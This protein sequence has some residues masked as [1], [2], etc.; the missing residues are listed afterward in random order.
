LGKT[1]VLVVANQTADSDELI[2]VLRTRARQGAARFTLLVPASPP[3]VT[4]D[5]D[6][7]SRSEE[8]GGQMQRALERMR[9]AGLDV[10]GRLGAPDPVAAVEGVAGQGERFDE[11]IVSTWPVPMSFWVKLDLPRRVEQAT[12]LSVR[13]VVSS[14]TQVAASR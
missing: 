1:H 10:E 6:M 14:A 11:A 3:G 13:H 12:G 8:A 2:D 9:A 4:W 5:P 7:H